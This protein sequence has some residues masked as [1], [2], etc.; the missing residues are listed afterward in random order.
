MLAII[1]GFL[2]TIAKVKD[3]VNKSV[4]VTIMRLLLNS[5]SF[6]KLASLNFISYNKTF[7][8]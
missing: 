1:N 2:C 5:I 4:A 7:A 6:Y 8:L 3:A